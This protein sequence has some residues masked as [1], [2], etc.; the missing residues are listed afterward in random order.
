[1]DEETVV[2]VPFYK[3]KIILIPFVLLLFLTFALAT[4]FFYFIEECTMDNDCSRGH[5]CTDEDCVKEEEES[6]EETEEEVSISIEDTAVSECDY[7]SDCDDGYSC[8]S[9]G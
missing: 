1:M 4:Y 3:K 6:T 7:D 2:F 5:V 9:G 8:D